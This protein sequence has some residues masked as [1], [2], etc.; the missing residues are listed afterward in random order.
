LCQQEQGPTPRLFQA[1]VGI[2]AY[3]FVRGEYRRVAEVGEQFLLLA[4]QH[5]DDGATLLGN[6][7]LGWATMYL[8]EL[9]SSLVHLERV[10]SLYDPDRHRSHNLFYVFDPAVAASCFGSVVSWLLGDPERSRQRME[11][12]HALARKR[13]DPHAR[14]LALTFGA[15][16]D[17]LRGDGESSRRQVELGLRLSVKYGF[18]LCGEILKMLQGVCYLQEGR[19]Q[20]GIDAMV[21]AAALAKARG[22][23]YGGTA[24]RATLAE[25]YAVS[26]RVPE[27]LAMLDE[28]FERVEQ[29]AERWWEPELYRTLGVLLERAPQTPVPALCAR[30]LGSK[31]PLAEACFRRAL[32]LARAM[33]ARSLELRSALALA[34]HWLAPEGSS[35]APAARRHRAR[36]LLAEVYEG[37]PADTTMCDLSACEA[38]LHELGASRMEGSGAPGP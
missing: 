21:D 31:T 7:L 19:L 9:E 28:A 24:W 36:R 35:K 16:N 3:H 6:L 18:M 34:R 26:A 30:A 22:T 38:L 29:R 37:F 5:K 33:K 20:A 23:E 4:A 2:G 12:A 25:A 13:S 1:L 27:A 15:K 11:Q 8:G 14:V 10:L 32:A 17:Q